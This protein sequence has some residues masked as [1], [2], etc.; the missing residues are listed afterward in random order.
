MD[1][2]H[3][4]NILNL[5]RTEG[6]YSDRIPEID[7]TNLHE[8]SLLQPTELNDF[9]NV[10]GKIVRQYIFD[11]TFT[12]EDNPFRDMYSEKLPVG[13]AIEDLYV[14][15]IKGAVPAWNDDGSEAFSKKLPNVAAIYHKENYENQYKVTTTFAQAR[16]AFMSIEGVDNLIARILEQLNTGYEYDL[17]LETLELLS[18]AYHNNV[19]KLKTGVT[20]DTEAGIKS[21]LKDFKTTVK[22][23]TFMTDKY[24][25]LGFTTKTPKE[26]LIIVTKPKYLEKINVDYLAGV[27]NIDK[28]EMKGRI[29]EVPDDYGF[30]TYDT[31]ASNIMFMVF[32]KRLLRIFN[33]FHEGSSAYN[34]AGLF[35]NTFLTTCWTFSYATFFNAVAFISGDAPEFSLTGAGDGTYCTAVSFRNSELEPTTDAPA[36]SEV[37]VVPVY[38]TGAEFKSAKAVFVDS[39]TGQPSEITITST[40]KFTMPYTTAEGV[41]VIVTGKASA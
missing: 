34:A 29:I 20:L 33:N 32:D 17:Y 23:M 9:I 21:F 14:D 3:V 12:S 13:V 22:D 37:T 2:T 18:T 36:G 31:N 40:L 19:F 27:F 15:L 4:L 11:T 39:R 5:A 7:Q 1:A 8:L 26:N 41:T 16:T 24:N 35:T 25:S 6:G 28:V 38:D 10:I 30:G